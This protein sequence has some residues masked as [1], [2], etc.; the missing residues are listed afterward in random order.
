MN[1]AESFSHEGGSTWTVATLAPDAGPWSW[2][3]WDAEVDVTPATRELVARAWD[4]AGQTQP[5]DVA[6]VWTFKGYMNNAWA[7]VPVA[8]V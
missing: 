1:V 5:P 7:R 2:R 3:F 8:L 4:S 6:H